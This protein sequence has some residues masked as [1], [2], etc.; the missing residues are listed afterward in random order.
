MVGYAATLAQADKAKIAVIGYSFGGLANVL[1]AAQDDRIS[2]LVALD[3]SVR[4]YP[5]IA[6]AATYATPERLAVPLL[7][8]GGKPATAEAMHRNNQISSYSL[9]NQL[10]YADFYNVTM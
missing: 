3:G 5:A 6:Q 7:Y 2:A 8:L 4:Y 1:A 9:L 10:K